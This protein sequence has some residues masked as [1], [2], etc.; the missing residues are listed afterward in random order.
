MLQFELIKYIEEFLLTSKIRPAEFGRLVADNP[1]LVSDLQ[2]G[3]IPDQK[4]VENILYYISNYN[5]PV[6][7]FER[8]AVILSIFAFC[9]AFWVFIYFH[10]L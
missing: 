6:F 1:M 4:T 3:K 5:R 9:C 10:L 7:N 2:Y 8:T